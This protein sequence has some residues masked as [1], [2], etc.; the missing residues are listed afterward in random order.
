MDPVLTSTPTKNGMR[1]VVRSEGLKD[2]GAAARGGLSELSSD[3]R[4]LR[5]EVEEEERKM[6]ADLKLHCPPTPV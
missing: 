6:R 4:E 5:E 2:L 3:E 1:T